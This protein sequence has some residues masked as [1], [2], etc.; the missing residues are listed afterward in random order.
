MFG[1]IGSDGLIG[2]EDYQIGCKGQVGYTCHIGGS[3]LFPCGAVSSSKSPGGFTNNKVCSMIITLPTP[4]HLES[5]YNE[6]C[7]L[8]NGTTRDQPI[9]WIVYNISPKFP[10]IFGFL[11]EIRTMYAILY[12]VR[13]G[14]NYMR[15]ILRHHRPDCCV[16]WWG[17]E[18]YFRENWSCRNGTNIH[19]HYTP[20]TSVIICQRQSHD[21]IGPEW[22]NLLQ[23]LAGLWC[24]R[25]GSDNAFVPDITSCYMT[26]GRY[27]IS[28]DMYTWGLHYS[29]KIMLQPI[30]VEKNWLAAVPTIRLIRLQWSHYDECG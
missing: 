17:I 24:G 11:V 30:L 19:V 25:H 12:I 20:V 3:Y 22:P 5:I 9:T 27:S 8:S 18:G 4:V 23:P 16:C 6:H 14:W 13:C 2:N 29:S 15:S 7:G 1:D 28:H 10:M 26:F 21:L